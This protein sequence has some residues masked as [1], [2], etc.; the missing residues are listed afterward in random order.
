MNG[1]EAATNDDTRYM[2]CVMHIIKNIKG[3]LHHVKICLQLLLHLVDSKTELRLF[4][5]NLNVASKPCMLSTQM[6]IIIRQVFFRNLE[7]V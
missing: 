4:D 7:A 1:I 2:M 3:K 5:R 6:P